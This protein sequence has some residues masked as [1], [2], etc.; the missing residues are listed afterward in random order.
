M[1]YYTRHNLHEDTKNF[2]KRF[3]K[4]LASTCETFVFI[5]IGLG[6]CS[7][8]HTYRWPLIGVTLTAISVARGVNI[9]GLSYIING[10]AR[11]NSQDSS[12]TTCEP[13]VPRRFQHML[14]FCGLRGAIAFALAL[15]AREAYAKR[16]DGSAGA[17]G[18]MFTTTLVITLFSVL[19][20]GGSATWVMA[21]LLPGQA[22]SA[23]LSSQTRNLNIDHMCLHKFDKGYLKPFLT[24][25]DSTGRVETTDA[26]D[27][28]IQVSDASEAGHVHDFTPGP[29]H[30]V[31]SPQKRP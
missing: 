28:S 26:L 15:R 16:Q 14:W 18:A 20:Q 29:T 22:I 4:V 31:F 7:F 10:Y 25:G 19:V 30:S 11:R 8:H 3:F 5:Y 24:R 12:G 6:V 1:N 23:T 13:P 17:G 9:Y 27:T 2:N 21:K